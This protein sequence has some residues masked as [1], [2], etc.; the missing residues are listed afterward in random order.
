MPNNSDHTEASSV[1]PNFREWPVHLSTFQAQNVWSHLCHSKPPASPPISS[2]PPPFRLTSL[3]L[4]GVVA[5]EPA[6]LAV[7]GAFPPAT[8][9]HLSD[10]HNVAFRE[11]Q[12]Q[13]TTTD[14]GLL[15][16]GNTNV[17]RWRFVKHYSPQQ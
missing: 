17:V 16:E 5:G 12:L 10:G 14:R 15:T 9:H 11:A 6:C 8:L 7:E 13:Q 2:P 1:E 3:D 4:F